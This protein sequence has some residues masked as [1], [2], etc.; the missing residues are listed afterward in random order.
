MLSFFF[1]NFCH[2]FFI[3]FCKLLSFFFIFLFKGEWTACFYRPKLNPAADISKNWPKESF[4]FMTENTVR[5]SKILFWF[6]LAITAKI[7]CLRLSLC[8]LYVIR[9]QR[10]VLFVSHSFAKSRLTFHLKSLDTLLEH[11]K[12]L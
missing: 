9:H 1:Y 8:L 12:Y 7:F 6:L 5:I 2:F 11:H 3:F 4:F 10:L